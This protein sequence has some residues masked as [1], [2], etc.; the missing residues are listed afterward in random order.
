MSEALRKLWVELTANQGQFVIGIIAVI[1]I[2]LILLALTGKKKDKKKQKGIQQNLA[3]EE[4]MELL[5]HSSENADAFIAEQR[6]RV[7]EQ[8][9]EVME[10][11]MQLQKLEEQVLQMKNELRML[12]EAPQELKDKIKEINERTAAEIKAKIYKRSYRMLLVG[13][14]IGIIGFAFGSFVAGN[15]ELV[16]SWMQ[17]LMAQ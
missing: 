5:R 3:L 8:E 12:D 16:Q 14:F 15:R 11:Q 9:R 10:R 4:I 7:G 1:I 13:F 2:L 17:Q 6:A